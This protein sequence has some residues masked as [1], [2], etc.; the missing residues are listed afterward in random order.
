[1]RGINLNDLLGDDFMD[2]A[3]RNAFSEIYTLLCFL[4]V[5]YVRKIPH[6]IIKMFEELRNK[7]HHLIINIKKK[8]LDQP[9]CAEAR[10]ILANIYRD[11]W[12]SPAE[13][14]S[15]LKREEIERQQNSQN[16]FEQK[17]AR[18]DKDHEKMVTSVETQNKNLKL[19]NTTTINKSNVISPRLYDSA[20]SFFKSL[21]Y[22]IKRFFDNLFDK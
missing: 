19:E 9:L 15:I 17:I 22:K 12:C 5:D 6:N 13:R 3:Y 10:A 7:E 21:G 4:P 8:I 20:Y 16:S 2:V 11:Y 14:E 18:E 1:M